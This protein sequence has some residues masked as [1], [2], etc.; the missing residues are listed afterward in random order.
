MIKFFRYLWV[1]LTVACTVLMGAIGYFRHMLPDTY[2]VTQGQILQ[3][4]QL[5]ESQ[6]VELEKKSV[7]AT[8][9]Q[10]GGE[11]RTQLRL[12]GLF[13]LKEVTV[14]VTEEKTVMVCGIPFGI[15]LYTDGVLIVGMSDVDTAA[16]SVNPAAAAGVCVGDTILKINGEAVT[17]SRDV[18]RLINACGGGAV[19]LRLKR[20]GVEFDATFTPV[21]PAGESG[22]RVGLWVRDSTAGVGTLTFYDP[23]TGVFAG[24]GHAV[25]D[26]DT[27][28]EMSLSGGEIVPARIFGVDKSA[29]G[30]PGELNGCFEDG[31]WG[32]LRYNGTE[33]LYGTLTAR[34]AGGQAYPVAQKQQVHT[35]T[36]QVLVTLDGTEPQLYD[37]RIEKIKYGGLNSTRHMVVRV[38]D[39]RLLAIAGGI[40]QGMSGSPIIQ[41]GK[42]I[43]AVTHVLVDDPTKG[44]AIFAENMLETAQGVAEEQLKAAS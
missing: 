36:A 15:K 23:T 25:C 34:P 40:V 11:Y 8:A 3:V 39:S 14:S 22:Y 19:T 43:G 28:V 16:G 1:T 42:L 13:P 32:R 24:L 27:G 10:A 20:D 38:T 26:V 12:A 33:G 6:P 5:V 4:G 35:G 30:A 17:T 18:A 21:R 29:A 41:N 31:S 2:T 7:A 37:I 9:V 44:Y